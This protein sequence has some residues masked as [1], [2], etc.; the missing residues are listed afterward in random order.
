MKAPENRERRRRRKIIVDDGDDGD[1]RDGKIKSRNRL[2]VLPGDVYLGETVFETSARE[3][4]VGTRGF[5]A[6][7][8]KLV[9]HDQRGT[10]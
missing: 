1:D 5:S 4:K 3:N 8:G 6:I 7:A 9:V 10:V 2:A